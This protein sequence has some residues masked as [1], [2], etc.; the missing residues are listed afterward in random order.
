MG[1]L[2][3]VSMKTQKSKNC[4]LVNLNFQGIKPWYCKNIKNNFYKKIP[5]PC[6]LCTKNYKRLKHTDI[7]L[8]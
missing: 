2:L 5:C 7:Y 6:G 4:K 8:Y 3:K 1:E